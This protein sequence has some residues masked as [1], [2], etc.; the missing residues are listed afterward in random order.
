MPDGTATRALLL[1]PVIPLILWYGYHYHRTGFVF[2]NPEFFHYNVQATLHPVRILLA[3]LL[4]MWQTVGYMNL[5]LL[6]LAMLFAMWLP[7][8]RDR[9][10]NNSKDR[11]RIAPDIQFAFLSIICRLRARH[12]DRGRS[13]PGALHAPCRSASD[14][15]LRFHLVAQ[16]AAVGSV[17]AVVA[18]GF[19]AGLFVNPPYG[20]SIE[21]NLAYRDYIVLHEHAEQYLEARHPMSRVLTAW[22]ASD[23]L[24]RPY[25]GYVTRPMR[26]VRIENFTV[27]QLMLA[28]ELRSSFDVALVFST[29]LEPAHPLFEHWRTWQEW[30]RQFFG[31][32]HD[33]PP[34]AAAQLLGGRLVYTE[35]RK[36][37]WI[38][39]I[40]ME[41]EYEARM[42]R[43]ARMNS[44]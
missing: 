9:T 26:V 36:G 25:L 43:P 12:V 40:E 6:T 42:S 41:R 21:D 8:L 22:P 19:I 3:F 10:T 30:K 13:R 35:A 17:A 38:G 39:V 33:V 14:R 7:P 11:P 31:Y 44:D 16:G 24:T 5:S 1:I 15:D 20:F 4:R 29:K 34:A 27:E 37:Q 18:V 28:S 32:Y 2:G 23:E